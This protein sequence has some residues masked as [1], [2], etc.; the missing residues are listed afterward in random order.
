MVTAH[1]GMSV[2]VRGWWVVNGRYFER[3]RGVEALKG[4]RVQRL[5]S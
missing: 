1:C 4:S 5:R 2:S 3:N